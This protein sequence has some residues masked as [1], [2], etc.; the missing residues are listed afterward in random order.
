MV[1]HSGG[2]GRS[3]R[4]SRQPGLQ[5]LSPNTKKNQFKNTVEAGGMVQWLTAPTALQRTKCDSQHPYN[6]SQPSATSVPPDLMLSSGFCKHAKWY[7][8]ICAD[9]TS[10]L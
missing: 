3:G 9:R 1:V 7:T 5:T 4:S 10:I 8:D 6:G 2:K